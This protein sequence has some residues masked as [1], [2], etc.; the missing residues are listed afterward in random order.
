MILNIGNDATSSKERLTQNHANEESAIG[1]SQSRQI[2]PFQNTA[3]KEF[4]S[5]LLEIVKLK[6][7]NARIQNRYRER[8][9]LNV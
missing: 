3:L 5:T 6:E 2:A 1:S 7:Q 8:E 4:E 9:E